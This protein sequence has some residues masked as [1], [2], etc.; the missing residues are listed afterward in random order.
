MK[1]E[2]YILAENRL[3]SDWLR[4]RAMSWVPGSASVTNPTG[5][6]S[7]F[8]AGGKAS[9]EETIALFEGFKQQRNIV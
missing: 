1:I 2:R 6:P 7:V 9:L 4:S 8:F 3:E 5:Y